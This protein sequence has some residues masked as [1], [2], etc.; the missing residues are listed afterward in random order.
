MSA[1]F[2][3]VPK[4]PGVPQLARAATFVDLILPALGKSAP[5]GV[6]WKASQS[7]PTWG[8]LDINGVPVLVPD[9][10]LAFDNR[11]EWK[12][13]DF[14]VQ[15]G[16]FASYNKVQIPFEI[17]LR[18]TKGGS[19]SDREQFLNVLDDIA[20]DT[21]LYNILTPERTYLN[22]NITRTEVT[23]RGPQ[24]AYFLAEV[25]IY[26]RQIRQVSAQY[27]AGSVPTAN[28]QNPPAVPAVNQ[29]LVQST[30]LAASALSKFNGLK[31]YW[32]GIV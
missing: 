23:R 21:N 9:S 17:T 26:F 18:M 2:P 4:L 27:S 22:V 29:G 25:D 6:L 10:F 3:V 12:V 8:I 14:P 7:Q 20:G 11:N 19:L 28:A 15:Q 16:S 32:Q 1:L 5:A 24:G 31:Q 30:S 13:S